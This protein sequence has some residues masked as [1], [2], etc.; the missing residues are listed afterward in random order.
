[1]LSQDPHKDKDTNHNLTISFL[2]G[3]N[4]IIKY[5]VI[6]VINNL[7]SNKATRKDGIQV[8]I[9]KALGELDTQQERSQHNCTRRHQLKNDRT[10]T[11]FNMSCIK[12]SFCS[13]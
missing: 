6:E 13:C 12:Y 4:L 9:L 10:N 11:K 7:P 5:N 2:S 8:E 3:M 1:M